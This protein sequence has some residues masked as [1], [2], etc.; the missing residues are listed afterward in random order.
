MNKLI[1]VKSKLR[2]KR[3]AYKDLLNDYELLRQNTKA[4]VEAKR[5]MRKEMS[6]LIKE[7]RELKKTNPEE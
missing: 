3:A 7:Y 1:E 4:N 2:S 6:E 5:I